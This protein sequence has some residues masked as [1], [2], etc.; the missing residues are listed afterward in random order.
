MVLKIG[1]HSLETYA[2][3]KFVLALWFAQEMISWPLAAFVHKRS[4][5]GLILTRARSSLS[6]SQQICTVSSASVS[7]SVWS[8]QAACSIRS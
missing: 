2:G 7:P 4:G 5:E 8:L 1:S 3:E 6:E